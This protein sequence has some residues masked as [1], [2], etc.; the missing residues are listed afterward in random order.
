MTS[1]PQQHLDI[2]KLPRESIDYLQ[3]A[4]EDSE[5][6][7]QDV[8]RRNELIGELYKRPGVEPYH[9]HN[10]VP[11]GGEPDAYLVPANAEIA[12]LTPPKSFEEHVERFHLI[13]PAL[14]I[15]NRYKVGFALR[16]HPDLERKVVKRKREL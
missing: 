16:D 8:T 4:A 5:V 12:K 10:F 13:F 9:P 1:H 15:F 11:P 14:M 3:M 2:Y 6:L 7:S